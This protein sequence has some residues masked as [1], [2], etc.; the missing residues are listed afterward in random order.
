MLTVR[1]VA[2]ELGLSYRAA[3]ELVVTRAL[4]AIDLRAPGASRSA[5]RVELSDLE[6]FKRSRETC[7]KKVG[8]ERAERLL[9]RVVPRTSGA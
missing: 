9:A 8:A 7:P 6:E 5:W 4:R 2:A 3:L 1:R